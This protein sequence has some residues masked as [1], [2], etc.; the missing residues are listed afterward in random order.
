VHP[1]AGQG[2]NLGFSD[3]D[4]LTRLIGGLEKP[5]RRAKLRQFERQRKSE[6]AMATHLFSGLKW[7][8]G[9][10]NVAL[11]RLRD[12]GMLLVQDNAWC[13]RLLMRQAIRNMA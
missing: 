4:L 12:L 2:V 10:D 11:S 5:W 3:V 7:I 6:T 13:R 8:Y 1:L 9:N